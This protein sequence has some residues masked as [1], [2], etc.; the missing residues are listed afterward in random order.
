M[1]IP[2]NAILRIKFMAKKQ[3]SIQG[4]KFGD[5]QNTID[6]LMNI[7][8]ECSPNNSDDNVQDTR[9]AEELITIDTNE[10]D[11]NVDT[12][13]VC[14]TADTDEVIND[15]DNNNTNEMV[16]NNENSD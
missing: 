15:D 8:V 5:R 11:N 9:N 1:K 16:N 6:Q 13:E 12:D 4:L 7:G 10:V 2:E 14:N 3:R